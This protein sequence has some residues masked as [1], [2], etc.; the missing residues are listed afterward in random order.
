MKH[1]LRFSLGVLMLFALV[2]QTAC[3]NGDSPYV[4]ERK[5]FF[6]YMAADNTLGNGADR[7]NLNQMLQA[8]E[9]RYF[10]LNNRVLIYH[11]PKNDVPVMLEITNNRHKNNTQTG[12]SYLGA[13]IDT[14]KVYE[15]Q[16]AADGATLRMAIADMLEFA[17]A[18]K[19]GL[20]LWS[21]GTGWFP[22]GTSTTYRMERMS[23]ES[24]SGE[25]LS[26]GRAFGQDGTDWMELADLAGAIPDRLF[27][28]I[29]C[30]ACY[31]GSV[32]VA[33]ALRN[34]ATYLLASP[35]EEEA[36][37]MPYH[38][39]LDDVFASPTQYAN[40]CREFYTFYKNKDGF[41]TTALYDLRRMEAL[42]DVMARIVSAHGATIP[43]MDIAGLQQYGR[44]PLGN[45]VFDM[46][47]FV[48]KLVPATD[49]LLAE[50]QNVMASLIRYKAH[51][52]EVF[53][54]PITSY[55]GISTYIPLTANT[56]LNAS[57]AETTW[58]Q[59]VYP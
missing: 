14:L 9:A 31:M 1:I 35:A 54:I 38:L 23:L 59:R 27:D 30:D 39:I 45:K 47:D 20:V 15:P 44:F 17:P 41:A 40:I 25:V 42:A 26:R 56:A 11:T 48:A 50:Y 10:G 16:S 28:F 22:A 18:D 55:S 51:T 33:Y 53:Y 2:G 7:A 4:L 13:K 52:D 8:Y 32:E 34:K 43:S 6:V 58:S 21:H 57:Y 37:G 3:D 49:P 5:T 24:V 46:T 19:Y 12:G 36:G 29:L